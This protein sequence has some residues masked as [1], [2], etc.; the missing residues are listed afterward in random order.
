[1]ARSLR[2]GGQLALLVP[3]VPR[4]FGA[5]DDVYGHWR[6]YDDAM[7]RAVV[8][9][10]GLEIESVRAMNSPGVAAWWLKNRRPGARVGEGS[11]SAFE[12]VVAAWRPIEDRLRPRLGLSL[13]LLAR[14]PATS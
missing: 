10:S 9:A 7:L 11:L 4:L 5:L 8:D 3:A 12:V 2:P 14:K 13:S 6:R 1:M